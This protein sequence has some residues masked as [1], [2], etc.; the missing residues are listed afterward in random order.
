MTQP[1]TDAIGRSY[2]LRRWDTS[3]ITNQRAQ[4]L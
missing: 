4:I 1:R 2:D 3:S